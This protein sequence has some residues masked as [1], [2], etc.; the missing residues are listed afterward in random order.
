MASTSVSIGGNLSRCNSKC[1]N[2]FNVRYCRASDVKLA[3][4][5]AFG[6][7]S[8]ASCK[9]QEMDHRKW[10]LIVQCALTESSVSR[11]YIIIL[12]HVFDLI[13]FRTDPTRHIGVENVN[14]FI[15]TCNLKRI[16]L[17][18][19]DFSVQLVIGHSMHRH[20]FVYV[21]YS[22]FCAC[23]ECTQS[24]NGCGFRK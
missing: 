2:R 14:L 18:H 20:S 23:C 22:S 15:C 5:L 10:I 9:R 8:I 1:G 3:L 6:I 19:N 7:G 12:L 11:D 13:K 17:I 24:T 21:V 4:A 16:R